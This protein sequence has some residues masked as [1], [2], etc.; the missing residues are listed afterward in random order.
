MP[1]DWPGCSDKIQRGRRQRWHVQRLTNVAHG[2]GSAPALMLVQEGAARGE[3]EQYGAAK[4]RQ[5]APR[6]RPPRYRPP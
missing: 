2:I 1:G 6:N 3:E 5:R 4:H